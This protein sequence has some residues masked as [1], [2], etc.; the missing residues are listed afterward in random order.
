MKK[1]MVI[2]NSKHWKE[3]Q[4]IQRDLT[5]SGYI[6]CGV[7]LLSPRENFSDKQ[8]RN[9]DEIMVEHLSGCDI[10]YVYKPKYC[11]LESHA[12]ALLRQARDWDKTILYNG[13]LELQHA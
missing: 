8:L 10:V 2:G 13:R 3:I 5:L 12:V 11:K 1:V 9:V 6:V 7:N 4:N